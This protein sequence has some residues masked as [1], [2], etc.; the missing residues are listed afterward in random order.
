[1]QIEA[2]ARGIFRARDV[3]TIMGMY[4]YGSDM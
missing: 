2:N 1:M 3:K 4:G